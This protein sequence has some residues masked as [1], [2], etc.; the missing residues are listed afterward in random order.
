MEC[1]WT[2][3]WDEAIQLAEEVSSATV[4]AMSY[5]EVPARI[6]HGLIELD[7][8]DPTAAAGQAER[9]LE[10]AL[11]IGDVQV[12]LPAQAF[13]ARVFLAEGGEQEA[14]DLV[15][16]ALAQLPGKEAWAS[17]SWAALGF[18][19]DALGLPAPETRGASTPWI[20]ACRLFVG[21]EREQAAD[22]Y[23]EIGAR[24]EEALAR[25]RA[26][27]QLVTAG[28]RAEAE[29]QLEAAIAFYREVRA[30]ARLDEAE[31]LLASA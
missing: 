14:R 6:T 29:A 19:L 30:T 18:L 28:R 13:R 21:G 20:D 15:E 7:R 4:A 2:G 24:P 31:A 26:A 16:S 17:Y 25:L 12:V 11:E 9:A 3:R 23:A 8:G 27:G 10:R 1:Y 22:L 5:M